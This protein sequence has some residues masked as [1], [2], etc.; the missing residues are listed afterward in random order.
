VPRVQRRFRQQRRNLP[1]PKR[2]IRAL[3]ATNN[4]FQASWELDDFDIGKPLGS[5]KFGRVFWAR[6]KRT[7]FVVALKVGIAK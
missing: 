7:G 6:E 3:A 4:L 2:Y 5:G 1:L